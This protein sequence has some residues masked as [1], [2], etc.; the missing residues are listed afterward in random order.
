MGETMALGDEKALLSASSA[1]GSQG[2]EG[3]GL[4]GTA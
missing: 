2:A 3:W 4:G 1:G